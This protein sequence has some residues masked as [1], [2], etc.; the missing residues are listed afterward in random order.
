MFRTPRFAVG[1]VFALALFA[2]VLAAACGDGGGDDHGDSD[3][4]VLSALSIL[5]KAGLHDMADTINKKGEIPAAARTTALKLQTLVTLTI[6]PS[7]FGTEAAALATILADM[8][9]SLDG[10]KP[11]TQAAGTAATKAHEAAH[12]FTDKVWLHLEAKAKVSDVKL[13]VHKD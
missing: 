11:D 13:E 9:K 3:A 12:D 5:D 8:A 10:E 6:W 2:A 1:A 7:E 4:G